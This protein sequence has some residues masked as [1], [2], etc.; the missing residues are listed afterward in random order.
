ML[1]LGQQ[2]T[3]PGAAIQVMIATT[4]SAIKVP[5][6]IPFKTSG[7]GM[8]FPAQDCATSGFSSPSL[9]MLYC[10]EGAKSHVPVYVCACVCG[11]AFLHAICN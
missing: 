8:D 9:A 4:F 6:K 2:Q 1:K 7:H 10:K 5:C 3:M 11:C